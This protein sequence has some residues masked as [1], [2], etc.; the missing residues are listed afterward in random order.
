MDT[1]KHIRNG[2]ASVSFVMTGLFGFSLAT[3]F[4]GVLFAISMVLIQAAALL[5]LPGKLQQAR[6]KDSGAEMALYGASIVTA[7]LLSVTASVATLSGS[8]EQAA[9][10]VAEYNTLQTAV[11]GY[12]EAG[13]ITRALEVK[14]E[15]DA[16]PQPEVTPLIAAANRVTAF[17]GWEGSQLVTGFIAALA[18]MLDLFVI[19]LTSNGVTVVTQ[20]PIMDKQPQPESQASHQAPP[21]VH[22]APEVQPQLHITPE[23]QAVVNAINDGLIRKPSVREVRELLRCSQSDAMNIARTCR[24]LE[25]SI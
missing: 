2:L 16:L 15:L 12:M 22:I 17:T 8:Y 13:F 24:Q 4:T 21:Q 7:L 10:A 9:M 3:G 11:D 23:V 5:H 20:A 19:L 18:L 14:Q 25:L 1:N 6:D